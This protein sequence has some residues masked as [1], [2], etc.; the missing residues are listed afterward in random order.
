MTIA[1]ASIFSARLSAPPSKSSLKCC[2]HIDILKFTYSVKTDFFNIKIASSGK[3][4]RMSL[5]NQF[6]ITLKDFWPYQSDR[7]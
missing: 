5:V 4:G 2:H 3:G 7:P 1:A 6:Q